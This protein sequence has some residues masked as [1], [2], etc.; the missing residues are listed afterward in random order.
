MEQQR[1]VSTLPTGTP[2][3]QLSRDVYSCSVVLPLSH[4]AA[5][6]NDFSFFLS[7]VLKQSFVLSKH[8]VTSTNNLVALTSTFFL[9]ESITFPRILP[10][11]PEFPSN[12][13]S[14]PPRP[15]ATYTVSTQPSPFL[16]PHPSQYQCQRVPLQLSPLPEP[17]PRCAPPTLTP[18]LGPPI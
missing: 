1:L 3:T 11:V 8:N 13:H 15:S 14:L 17:M 7:K 2:A 16:H 18:Q 9:C 12:P 6:Q 4:L 10:F 5:R